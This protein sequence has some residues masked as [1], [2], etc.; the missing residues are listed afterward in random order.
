MIFWE[1]GLILWEITNESGF[2]HDYF[3]VEKRA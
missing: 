2:F 1:D 3:S